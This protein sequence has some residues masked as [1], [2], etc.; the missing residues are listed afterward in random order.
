MEKVNVT[1]KYVGN[2]DFTDAVPASAPAQTVKIHAL[3][4]FELEPSS[5][6][7]YVLQFNGVDVDDKAKVGT[8]GSA[9]VFT[10]VLKEDVVKG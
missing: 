3:K 9:P 7:K 4:Q 6:D 5:A 1:V 2:Q 10:L 8:F